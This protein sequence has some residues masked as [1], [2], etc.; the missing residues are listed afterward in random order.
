[1]VKWWT[2][3]QVKYT[4]PV[5]MEKE[6]VFLNDKLIFHIQASLCPLKSKDT[7]EALWIVLLPFFSKEEAPLVP[8]L[9]E[10]MVDETRYSFFHRNSCR[11]YTPRL[12]LFRHLQCSWR[13]GGVIAFW[14]PS[15]KSYR[16]MLC[17]SLYHLIFSAQ[18]PLWYLPFF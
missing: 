8:H 1:M 12:F 9:G 7:R 3:G 13:W 4:S 14:F 16:V 11:K 5:E 15:W 17:N 10:K 18:V 2:K 6:W